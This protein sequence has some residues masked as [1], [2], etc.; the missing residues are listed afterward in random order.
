[1]GSKVLQQLAKGGKAT[2]AEAT[3]TTRIN[4]INDTVNKLLESQKAIEGHLTNHANKGK[5]F[6]FFM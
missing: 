5:Q 1:M 2:V 4:A 3:Y 6:T